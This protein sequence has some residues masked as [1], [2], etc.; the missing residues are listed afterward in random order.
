MSYT[1]GVYQRRWW[2]VWDRIMGGH[3]I[4]IVGWGTQKNKIEKNVE[5]WTIANSWDTTWGE[6]GYFRIK[7]GVNMCGI[8]SNVYA[9]LPKIN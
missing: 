1:S 6:N 8:E 5:Y 7:R 2:K 3:A 9:G 4:K